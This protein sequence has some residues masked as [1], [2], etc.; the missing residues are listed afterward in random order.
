M[1]TI[2]STIIIAVTFIFLTVKAGAQPLPPT[3][4]M[5]NPIPMGSMFLL[6]AL[7]FLA[8]GIHKLKRRK[9]NG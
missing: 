6:S 5:G 8:F 2:L 1:K 7:V 4:P 9:N 3:N